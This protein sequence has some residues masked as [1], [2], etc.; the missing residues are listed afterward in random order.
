M[1][2]KLEH[3]FSVVKIVIKKV[4]RFEKTSVFAG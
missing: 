2:N 1:F 3:W 4:L